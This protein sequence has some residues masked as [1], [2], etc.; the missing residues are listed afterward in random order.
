MTHTS[1]RIREGVAA[2]TS[3]PAI[4]VHVVELDARVEAWIAPRRHGRADDVAHML[5]AAADQAKITVAVS[6]LRWLTDRRNGRRVAARTVVGVLVTTAAV[7]VFKQRVNRPR[8]S[9]T[10]AL[11]YRVRPQTSASFPSGHAV[12]AAMVAISVS[13]RRPSWRLPL[14]VL[15][16]AIAWSRVQVGLHHAS[17]V[18][19]GLAIGTFAGMLLRRLV[20]LTR[21]PRDS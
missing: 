7:D 10:V 5:S 9:N 13:D 20:P 16:G 11:R 8:P 3:E 14:V 15:A 19:G 12:S 1:T 6:A 4:P 18:I 2:A 17:D 21:T